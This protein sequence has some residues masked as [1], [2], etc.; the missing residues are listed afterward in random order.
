MNNWILCDG[1]WINFDKLESLYVE[2][3]P[4]GQF[5]IKASIAECAYEI[6]SKVFENREEAQ[7]YLNDFM[8]EKKR[9]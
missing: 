6:F 9:K 8:W 5:V 4:S 7:S 1:Q 3:L 2:S